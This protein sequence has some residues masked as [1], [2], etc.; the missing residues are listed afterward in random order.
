MLKLTADHNWEHLYRQHYSLY[1]AIELHNIQQGDQIMQEH[2]A[3]TIADQE[4]L[5][6]KYPQYY[7]QRSA[8]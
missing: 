8:D 7:K 6:E 5:M 2:M 3:L 1:E 4:M